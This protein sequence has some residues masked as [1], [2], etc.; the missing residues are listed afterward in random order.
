MNS[1]TLVNSRQ[2]LRPTGATQWVAQTV[3][4][5][6]EI[7][8]AT[9]EIMLTSVGTLP[10]ELALVQALKLGVTVEVCVTSSE[11]DKDRDTLD[12]FRK[13]IMREFEIESEPPEVTLIPTKG[14]DERDTQHLRDEFV[15]RNSNRI[16][17]IA[18]RPGGTLEKIL[19]QNKQF[20][21]KTYNSFQIPYDEK[22]ERIKRNY[23]QSRIDPNTQQ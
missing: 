7:T 14:I 22:S 1:F 11:L 18:I 6:S 8:S 16:F 20:F 13:K 23:D 9:E 12:S 5:I 10:Y 21:S 19:N 2:A 17:P 15:L 4:A 3:R